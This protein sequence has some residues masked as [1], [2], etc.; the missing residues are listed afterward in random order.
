[1]IVGVLIRFL[2]WSGDFP[3]PAEVYP[4]LRIAI[5]SW[6][7]NAHAFIAAKKGFFLKYGV[8]V[9]L[10]LNTEQEQSV[11]QYKRG[12]VDGLFDVFSNTIMQVATGIPTKVVYISELLKI[13]RCHHWPTGIHLS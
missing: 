4:P 12:E 6:P 2:I 11:N 10:T 8:K 7:G 3:K 5:N 13:W 1:M 9:H